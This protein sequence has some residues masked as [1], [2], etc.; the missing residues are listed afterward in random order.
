[1]HVTPAGSWIPRPF[2]HL[3]AIDEGDPCIAPKRPAAHA[4]AA[5]VMSFGVTCRGSF[6]EEMMHP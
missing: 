5:N 2:L 1:L 4:L 6:H 3:P